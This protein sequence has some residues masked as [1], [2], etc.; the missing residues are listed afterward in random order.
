M[1]KQLLP[2]KLKGEERKTIIQAVQKPL[3]EAVL[4][5]IRPR[6]SELC[7]EE[8]TAKRKC[9]KREPRRVTGQTREIDW[10]C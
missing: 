5:A 2:G 4:A 9:G 3:Q 1:S 7:E 10:F 6:L 8:V